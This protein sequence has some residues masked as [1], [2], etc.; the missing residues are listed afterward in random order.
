ML[1]QLA[2]LI[3][4]VGQPVEMIQVRMKRIAAQFEAG[5]EQ[6]QQASSNTDRQPRNV[7]DGER[8]TDYGCPG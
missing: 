1:G 3:A 2:V 4:V 7:A 8:H 6:N 5:V